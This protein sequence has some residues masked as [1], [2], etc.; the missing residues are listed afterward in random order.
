[1]QEAFPEY[2]GRVVGL[3]RGSTVKYKSPANTAIY[4][5]ATFYDEDREKF[6]VQLERK[7]RATIVIDVSVHDEEGVVMM[8]GL[9]T[10]F[11]QKLDVS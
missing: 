2:V 7:G 4:A 6:I 3:L 9:F 10:W 11:V 5:K 1:L 8:Q